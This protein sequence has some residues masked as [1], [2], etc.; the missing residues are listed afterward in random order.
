[1]NGVRIFPQAQDTAG[2]E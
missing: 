1:M 2:H